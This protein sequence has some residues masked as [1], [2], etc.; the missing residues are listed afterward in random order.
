MPRSGSRKPRE[1][2]GTVR[3]TGGVKAVVDP[4]QESASYTS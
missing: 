4:D 2:V 1:K 3:T